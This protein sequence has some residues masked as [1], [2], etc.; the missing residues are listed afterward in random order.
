[1]CGGGGGGMCMCI[2][3][4]MC[5]CKYMC[6]CMCLGTIP[7]V[8][9]QE[10]EAVEVPLVE[11]PAEEEAP[12]AGEAGQGGACSEHKVIEECLWSVA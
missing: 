11:E 6:M 7:G 10:P 1:M 5:M 9:P 2:C 12:V 3:M 8:P 4:C